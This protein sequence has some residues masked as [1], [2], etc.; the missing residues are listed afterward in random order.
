[1]VSQVPVAKAHSTTTQWFQ[2]VVFTKGII[3]HAQGYSIKIFTLYQILCTNTYLWHGTAL[4]RHT[5][6]NRV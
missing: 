1:M 4:C 2:L 5:S 6:L 3:K